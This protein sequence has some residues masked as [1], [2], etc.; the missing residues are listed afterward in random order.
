MLVALTLLWISLYTSFPPSYSSYPVAPDTL[1]HVS[2]KELLVMLE[3]V[4]VEG[5][6]GTDG[7][8]EAARVVTLLALLA[9][10]VSKE[11][12]AFTVKLYVVL[13]DNPVTLKLVLVPLYTCVPPLYS[14]YPVAPVT[15]FH[16]SVTEELVIFEAV[17]VEG[18][19]SGNPV[20]GL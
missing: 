14:S 2:V 9:L 4:G 17:G 8:V 6:A 13:A 7:F 12:Y 11:S 15:L 16:V 3:A 10:D 5:V 18:A 1:F 20:L 19:G